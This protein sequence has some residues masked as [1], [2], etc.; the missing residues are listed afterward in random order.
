MVMCIMGMVG[1]GGCTPQQRVRSRESS[2]AT[3][4]VADRCGIAPSPDQAATPSL[5]KLT[6]AMINLFTSA[7]FISRFGV[8][9]AMF[10]QTAWAALRN[11]TQIY[12]QTLGGGIGMRIIQTTQLFNILGSGGGFQLCANSYVAALSSDAERTANFGVIGGVFMLGSAAGFSVGGAAQTFGDLV[13]FQAAF[14]MLCACTLFGMFFLPYYAPDPRPIQGEKKRGGV[15]SP[16]RVFVPRKQAHS[17]NRDWNLFFLGAG[18]FFSV[19][20]TGYVA[21]ALQLVATDVFHFKPKRTGLMLSLTLLVRAFF[22]SMCFPRIIARGRAWVA[23]L[24]RKDC[25][26]SSVSSISSTSSS[27]SSLTVRIDPAEHPDYASEAE[28]P[29]A[30]GQPTTDLA[31]TAARHGATFDLWFL[32]YSILLD[33]VLTGAVTFVTRDWHIFAAAAVLPFASGT[34]PAA[35]GVTLEFVPPDQRADAL[36][37]IALVEKIGG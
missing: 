4:T 19:L 11:L 5:V 34:G 7:W 8:K 24:D 22:L 23:R 1:M 18:T 25:R 2:T 20:A 21:M 12:A 30:V 32:R 10:Q 35:K 27:S 15:L 13:P 28:V 9:A 26:R 16:L 36:S 14:G 17:R 6:A 31:P 37:A 33:G 29:D 3:T